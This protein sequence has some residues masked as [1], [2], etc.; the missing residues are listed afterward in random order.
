MPSPVAD[1]PVLAA[2]VAPP[3]PPAVVARQVARLDHSSLRRA[4]ALAEI[5]G[6]PV[7]VRPTERSL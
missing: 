3:K 6:P 2:A 5:L 7:G 4:V 1:T